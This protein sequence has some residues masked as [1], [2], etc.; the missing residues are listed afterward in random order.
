MYIK[1]RDWNL[2]YENS[3]TRRV[4]N[5]L[6]VP[7]PNKQG[8]GYHKLMHAKDGLMIYGA[9]TALLLLASRCT[10]RGD[11][12]KYSTVSELSVATLIE[13]DQLMYA[14]R[15]LSDELDW[16]EIIERD[17]TDLFNLKQ[18]T[19]N[20]QTTNKQR[21][22]T[23][24][25]PLNNNGTMLCNNNNNSFSSNSFNP[26]ELSN[27]TSIY[28]I[29]SMTKAPDSTE[30]INKLGDN[31]L[32]PEPDS[33]DGSTKNAHTVD[34]DTKLTYDTATWRAD[35]E[36]YINGH[37]LAYREMTEDKEWLNRMKYLNPGLDIALSIE[38][39]RE[40]WRSKEGWENKKSK[41]KIKEIDWRSTYR[42]AIRQP[43]NRVFEQKFQSKIQNYQ[44][45]VTHEDIQKNLSFLGELV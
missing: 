29:T 2:H 3:I 6:Y 9:W 17:D 1:I 36:A 25:Q 39:A 5:I 23:V 35:Y 15:F 32:N 45:S 44:K 28:S 11:L 40:F 20:E 14:I 7:V 41:R 12:S 33:I 27:N 8:L 31:V 24:E 30:N 22:T 43:M 16:I 37:D 18:R 34:P 13:K 38:N 26:L 42:N 4:R 21:C 10:P 19:N